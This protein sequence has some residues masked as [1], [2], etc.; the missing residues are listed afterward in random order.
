MVRNKANGVSFEQRMHFLFCLSIVDIS[1]IPNESKVITRPEGST[2]TLSCL[3][4]SNVPGFKT[5]SW[6]LNGTIQ[7]AKDTN[8]LN[9]TV[10][11][12]LETSHA[13]ASFIV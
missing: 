9:L 7:H 4:P 13:E 10:M 3:F 2:I 11:L 1:I 12:T 5:I 8:I 6:I